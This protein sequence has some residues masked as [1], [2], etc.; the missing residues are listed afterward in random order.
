[1]TLDI[2]IEQQPPLQALE[3]DWQQMR[4][5]GPLKMLWLMLIPVVSA[6]VISEDSAG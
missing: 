3:I 1:M 5:C 4:N 2:Q 6:S